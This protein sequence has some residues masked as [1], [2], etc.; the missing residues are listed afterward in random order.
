M[1][2]RTNTL[3]FPCVPVLWLG[4]ILAAGCATG[5][6]FEGRGSDAM[7]TTRAGGHEAL[8]P[9][10]D[11]GVVACA[12]DQPCYAA[13]ARLAR[14]D[15]IVEFQ[16]VADDGSMAPLRNGELLRTGERFTIFVRT[17]RPAHVYLFHREP[18]GRVVELIAASGVVAGRDCTQW[19]RMTPGQVLQLPKEGEHFSLRGAGG[20]ERVQPVISS[21]PLCD[22]DALATSLAASS[23]GCSD[24]KLVCLPV[25]TIGHLAE[26]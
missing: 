3:L 20:V 1:R 15:V 2:P 12:E 5:M 4:L 16:R 19:N 23:A 6:R 24:Q 14:D 11:R 17:A 18:T 22:G 8:G 10:G 25:F 7:R 26:L 9:G 13:P 21:L